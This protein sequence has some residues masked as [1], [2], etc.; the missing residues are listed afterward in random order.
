M[1]TTLYPKN[2]YKLFNVEDICLLV[3][4]FYPEDF[5]DQKKIRLRFQLQHYKLDV[6]NHPKLKNMSPIADLCQG[7]V[8]TEKSTIYQLID[9][10]IRLALTLPVLTGTTEQ[11]FLAMK[12]VK[13]RLRNRMRDVFLANYLIVYIEKEIA[14]RFTINMIIDDFYAMKEQRAKLK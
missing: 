13:T 1:S 8:E 2:Y 3:D 12:I 11:G 5:S 6:P 9:K 10:L 4:K 7:L 14:E